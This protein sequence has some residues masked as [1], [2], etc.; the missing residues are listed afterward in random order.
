MI[1]SF[2]PGRFIE[3]TIFC[4]NRKK[5]EAIRVKNKRNRQIVRG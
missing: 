2:A 1:Y 4:K 3:R 5:G